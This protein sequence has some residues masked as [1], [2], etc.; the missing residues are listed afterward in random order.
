MS[1]LNQEMLYGLASTSDRSEPEV[2]ADEMQLEARLEEKIRADVT[3]RILR[4]ARAEV[5]IRVAL[6]AITRPDTTAKDGIQALFEDEPEAE[7]RDHVKTVV[8]DMGQE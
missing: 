2:T 6:A 5:Q 8:G 4:E 7:W 3:E 1:M